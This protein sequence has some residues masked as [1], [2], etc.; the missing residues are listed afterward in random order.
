M[1]LRIVGDSIRLRLTLKEIER[2]GDAGRMEETLRFP[3]GYRLVYVLEQ[4]PDADDLSASFDGEVMTVSVPCS[5]AREW[6]G[7]DQVG[8]ET[9]ISLENGALDVLVEKDFQCLHKHA[10]DADALPH[11]HAERIEDEQEDR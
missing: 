2:F 5:W 8:L 11:P 4:S 6:I 1:K 3:G 7:S 9:T 10:E